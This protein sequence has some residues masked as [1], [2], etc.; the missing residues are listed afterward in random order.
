MNEQT[1]FDTVVVGAGIAGAAIGAHLARRGLSVLLIEAEERPGYHATGRSAAF[2]LESYGGEAVVPLSAASRAFLDQPPA[3]F[4]PHG[5]LKPRGAIYIAREGRSAPFAHLPEGPIYEPLDPQRLRSLVPGLR[6]EW[7][8]GLAEPSCREIDVAALHQAYLA[9]FTRAGGELR[10]GAG[11]DRGVW[12]EGGWSLRLADGRTVRADRIVDAAGAWADDVAE[13]C[14]VAG[15]RIEPK[16]RTMLQLRIAQM[17]CRAL[18]LVNDADG[19]FYF[20]GAGDHSVWLSPHDE[21]ESVPCDA[22]PEELAVATAI[23]RLQQV[24]DWRIEAVERKWAGLRTFAPD[25]VPVIGWDAHQPGFFWYAGQ[26]GTG[27]QTQPAAAAL[28]RAIFLEDEPA[29]LVEGIDTGPYD[30]A[31]FE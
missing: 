20:R 23:D 31:R 29:G 26:G 16:C 12:D 9:S 17:E 24:V 8:Q 3:N 15:L 18:P 10:C 1:S 28:A 19:R 11:L 4:S 25:R 13:R 22:A 27:I 21:L 30:P 7:S 2:W 6:S 14:G 5:F